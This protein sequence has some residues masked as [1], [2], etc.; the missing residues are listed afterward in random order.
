[1][2]IAGEGVCASTGVG[3]KNTG[4][5]RED[6]EGNEDRGTVELEEVM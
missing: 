2:S 5:V 6:T 3:E 1:M 4:V